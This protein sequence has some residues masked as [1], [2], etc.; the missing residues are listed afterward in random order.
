M[1]SMRTILTALCVASV[2]LLSG[3]NSSVD[4]SDLQGFVDD[5]M[6]KPR[7]R[8][9]PIPVFKPYEFFNYSAAGMRSPFQLP[10]MPDAQVIVSGQGS[11]KPDLNRPKQFLEQFAIGTLS[12]VGTLQKPDGELWALV[13]DAD[14]GVVRVKEGY[15]M[16]QNHGRV[17]S[18][19]EYGINVVE[20]VP[21]GL[22]GWL[23]RPRTLALEGL[24]GE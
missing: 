17:T 2:A 7:G 15:Y 8:V 10:M 23:E 5:V 19:S 11:V 9:E 24:A 18:I 13:R 6:A 22:G 16:G 14:G 1:S 20:I 12:M 3:C 21:N 4:N